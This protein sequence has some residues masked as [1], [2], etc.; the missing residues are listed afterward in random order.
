[1]K[2]KENNGEEQCQSVD[3]KGV[4]FWEKHNWVCGFILLDLIKYDIIKFEFWVWV[5]IIC[6][7]QRN[8]ILFFWMQS[9]FWKPIRNEYTKYF[10]KKM[11]VHAL[12][13]II[14]WGWFVQYSI[15]FIKYKNLEIFPT[16]P[17]RV[18]VASNGSSNYSVFHFD[19]LLIELI[20]RSLCN[21]FY[22]NNTNN[23]FP[24]RSA[25]SQV[26]IFLR[27]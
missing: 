11:S 20:K 6:T 2:F 3:G 5:R 14:H 7:N 23:I 4:Q 15:T 12:F 19:F 17:L 1:M 21:C 16:Q 13:K 26:M 10:M 22:N 18:N 8:S 24:T 9:F 27:I 25:G